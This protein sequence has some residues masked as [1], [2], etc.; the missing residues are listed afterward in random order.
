MVLVN[1]REKYEV[2]NELFRVS[3]KKARNFFSLIKNPYKNTSIQNIHMHSN[4]RTG[5]INDL[6]LPSNCSTKPFHFL[7]DPSII[8]AYFISSI[9]EE[10]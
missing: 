9:E 8:Y 1:K 6:R 10:F 4:R 3:I 2:L 7:P 5:L